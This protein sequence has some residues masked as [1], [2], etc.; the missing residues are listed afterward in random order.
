MDRWGDSQ[1]DRDQLDNWL[2]REDVSDE[3]CTC[4]FL[5]DKTCKVC[6]PPEFYDDPNDTV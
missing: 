6:T 1:R 3:P 2:T 4:R 5:M